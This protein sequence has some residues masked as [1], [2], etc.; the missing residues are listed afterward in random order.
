MS[1]VPL[2]EASQRRAAAAVEND[3][4][5]APARQRPSG[6]KPFGTREQKLA[7]PNREGYHR[8]WFN[9][10]PGRIMR[11]Q[12]AGYTQVMGED[13]KPVCTPVGVARI[14]GG[15][16]IGYLMEIPIEWYREDM[17]AQ[18]AE[19]RKLMDQIRDG[20][21]PGAQTEGQY[22]PKDRGISIRE[23]RR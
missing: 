5:H 21:V 12:E 4:A 14:G 22:V 10:E 2:N 7:Y 8:H 9:D 18:E 15:V 6:R 11:A 13:G 19:Q 16:L 1:R 23:D 20:Q 17:A 3:L